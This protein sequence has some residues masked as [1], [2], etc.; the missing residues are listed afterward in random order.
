MPK[1]LNLIQYVDDGTKWT[2]NTNPNN[3]T[4]SLRII[5]L[6]QSD[7]PGTTI[8][9]GPDG[10]AQISDP[11]SDSDIANK[12]YVDD[13]NANDVHLAGDQTISGAKTFNGKTVLS[14]GATVPYST[15]GNEDS[16]IN[17]KYMSDAISA[18]I[19]TGQD[20]FPLTIGAGQ[21]SVVQRRIKSDGSTVAT[22]A[23][24]R[25]TASFG[26]N[27]VAGDKSGDVNAY[28]FA[29]AAN[30]NNEAIARSSAAFGRYNKTF[31]PG[32]F[33]CGN[34]ADEN[35]NAATIFLVG[36]GTTP[37]KRH[38]AFEVRTDHS[39]GVDISTA[40][41]GG[42]M[43]ATQDYVNNTSVHKEGVPWVIYATNKDEKGN[44]VDEVIPYRFKLESIKEAEF[45]LMFQPMTDGRIYT[46][47]PT[48]EYHA[49]NKGYVDDGW[50][51][52]NIENGTG[53]GSIEQKTYENDAKNPQATGLGAVA[54]GG[55]RG[56]KPNNQPDAEDRIS[57]AAGI[58]SATF[59]AGTQAHGNWDI[60]AGKDSDTYQKTSFAF[61]GKC[62][63]GDKSGDVNAYSFAFAANENSQAK[64][65][66]S[67]VFGRYNTSYNPGE[68]VC[69]NYADENRDAGTLF[70]VG[71]GTAQ[72]DGTILRHNAF[73]VRTNYKTVGTKLTINSSA[74][75]GGKMVATQEYVGNNA[76]KKMGNSYVLYG[77]ESGGKSTVIPYRFNKQSIIDAEYQLMFQPMTDGRLYTRYPTDEYHTANK[78]Y[79]DNLK[80]IMSE[81]RMIPEGKKVTISNIGTIPYVRLDLI[82]DPLRM[83]VS[84]TGGALLP[85]VIS[86]FSA[87]SFTIKINNVD[88][89]KDFAVTKGELSEK[90]AYQLTGLQFIRK[91]H[92]SGKNYSVYTERDD[93][94]TSLPHKV[95][96]E[97]T[98]MSYVS[99]G[100]TGRYNLYISELSIIIAG[101]G[102]YYG[103]FT[104]SI[105]PSSSTSTHKTDEMVDIEGVKQT[106]ESGQIL[107]EGEISNDES[108]KVFLTAE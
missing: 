49:A 105:D 90:A 26:G 102:S 29:F 58:Q 9:R 44:V 88:H 95:N 23:Y 75:I 33:V 108:I 50:N 11:K 36:G 61:G 78:G 77:N 57:I 43:V 60:C 70:V 37:A 56:D 20:N 82:G 91:K 35:R 55:F 4:S 51:K 93:L 63:A 41:I 89:S 31:N 62:Q 24:Q 7:E 47:Y 66:S 10:T 28:S 15:I 96:K 17:K 13:Q 40:Y 64:A 68:F 59:G 67:A 71:G 79:V 80:S 101:N 30:E 54:F 85:V 73:E 53:T 65:R 104:L 74:F 46:R 76:V 81:T 92:T 21:Y 106:L 69:G 100:N 45:H 27:T 52:F 2:K 3:N 39:N 103:N 6:S 5:K 12:K 38:N 42:R 8:M 19:S 94:T 86:Y 107:I 32:E 83:S 87:S 99:E 34:Y 98:T 25:G 48:D 97:S 16:V 1:F 22:E 18:A 14:G 84:D 72:S